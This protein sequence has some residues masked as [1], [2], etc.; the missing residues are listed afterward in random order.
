MVYVLRLSLGDLDIVFGRLYLLWIEHTYPHPQI[1]VCESV[2]EK[3][4]HKQVEQ[5]L[6]TQMQMPGM[7]RPAT[8]RPAMLRRAHGKARNVEASNVEVR[9]VEAS[10]VEASNVEAC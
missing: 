7:L 8:V 2:C 1:E 9:N 3:G 6:V 5:P 4:R 10:S